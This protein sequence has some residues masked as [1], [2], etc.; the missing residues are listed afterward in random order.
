MN[1]ITVSNLDQLNL[2][3][4]DLVSL[5]GGLSEEIYHNMWCVSLEGNLIE[6]ITFKQLK[7]FVDELIKHRELQLKDKIFLR[8][9][10]FYMWFDQQAL[11]LRFNIIT[12]DATSLPFECK[13][14]LQTSPDLILNKFINTV[15]DVARCGDQIE[16]F[17]SKDWEDE[18]EEEYVLDVFVKKLKVGVKA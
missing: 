6:S 4:N 17:D 7:S 16:F 5:S 2:I 8:G 9:V 13:I 11:Q 18:N 14:Q 12:G 10:V 1:V 3:F 15:K